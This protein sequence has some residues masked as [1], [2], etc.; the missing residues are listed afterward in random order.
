VN[1]KVTNLRKISLTPQLALHK[2]MQWCAYQERSQHEARLKLHQMGL[3]DHEAEEL[4]ATLISENFLNE[5]RFA[6]A[7][8][9]GKFRIKHWGRNKIR[10]ELRQHKVT[11]ACIRTALQSID[12]EVY[13]QVMGRVI[14]KKLALIK[15]RDARTRF[16]NTLTYLV[17]RGFES[18][19]ARDL[20]N[21]KINTNFTETE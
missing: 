14:D 15:Q 21:E 16:Y 17:S 11:E 2:M 1:Y 4:L 20:L 3:R 13:I 7:F 10:M 18:D 5:E 8:A 19:L 9:G 6:L 12:P